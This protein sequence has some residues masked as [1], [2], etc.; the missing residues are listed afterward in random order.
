MLNFDTAEDGKQLCRFLDEHSPTIPVWRQ[1]R[2]SLLIE[3]AE[4][5]EV[6]GA[7]GLVLTGF[8]RCAGLSANQNLHIPGEEPPCL[9]PRL[10][11]GTLCKALNLHTLFGGFRVR[12]QGLRIDTYLRFV[13]L[14]IVTLAEYFDLGFTPL[15]FTLF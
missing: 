15:I 6:T 8:I 3:S 1:Q 2:P 14:S 5:C 4:P 11:L 9:L 10:L 12:H 7:P 13:L